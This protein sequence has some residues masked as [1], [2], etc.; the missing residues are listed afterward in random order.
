LKSTDNSKRDAKEYHVLH[1][2]CFNLA[3]YL[4]EQPLP[5]YANRSSYE[6]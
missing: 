2:Y 6:L 1:S 4:G 5:R 3:K